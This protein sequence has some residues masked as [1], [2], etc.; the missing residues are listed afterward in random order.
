V[1]RLLWT[2]KRSIGPLPRFGHAMA[3]DS[4]RGRAV[5]FGG[6]GGGPLFGDTWE[7]DGDNWTQMDDIGPSR[8]SLHSMAFAGSGTLLFGGQNG[9]VATADT[10]LW[11]GEDWT[12]LADSGPTSRINHAMAFDSNRSRV[13]LFGGAG[14]FPGQLQVLNDTWEWDGQEWTQQE[15]IGP[16][17]RELH[18]MA[19]D[20]ARGRVVLFGGPDETGQRSLGD[21]WEWDGSVWTQVSSFGATPC[22]GAALAYKGNATALFGGIESL[23]NNPQV[24]L[25]ANTWEWDGKHWALRQDIGPS[26]RWRHAMVYDSQRNHMVLFGGLSERAP[27]P[28][29]LLGDTWEHSEQQSQPDGPT[30]V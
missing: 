25:F 9:A 20:M 29:A 17:A 8:R 18:V 12:Q 4:A 15:D 24:G 16:P 1:S 28:S 6:D 10:W 5:L 27:G 13:V 26:A 22:T 30:R 21:T 23:A 19:Y 2:Q 14:N 7:W 3:Y 11:N